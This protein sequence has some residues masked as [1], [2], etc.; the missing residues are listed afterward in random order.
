MKTIR[1][2]GRALDLARELGFMVKEG[3]KRLDQLQGD[4]DAVKAT[5]NREYS[6]KMKEILEVAG[7]EKDVRGQVDAT[8]LDDHGL[9]FVQIIDQPSLADILENA[10]AS[11]V[12]PQE[13]VQ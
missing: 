13:G 3:G 1:L 10:V 7:V 6:N 11:A 5:L 2:E 4:I 12:A 9:A 8:Y